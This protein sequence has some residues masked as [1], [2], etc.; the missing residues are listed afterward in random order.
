[1][2]RATVHRRIVQIRPEVADVPEGPPLL[3]SAGPWWFDAFAPVPHDA[4]VIM[5]QSSSTGKLVVVGSCVAVVVVDESKL[6]STST[7]EVAVSKETDSDL[8]ER[9]PI[10]FLKLPNDDFAFFSVDVFV[11]LRSLKS[12]AL[13]ASKLKPQ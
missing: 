13:S 3:C 6:K 11:I 4:N 5:K 10:C 9:I 12:L 1:M 7:L 2:V 8:D